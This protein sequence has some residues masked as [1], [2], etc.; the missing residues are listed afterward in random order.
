MT[1]TEPTLL[2][3][4]DIYLFN[5]GRGVR[6]YDVLGAHLTTVDGK[7]GVYFAVWAP[8]AASV[9]V[10]GDFNFWGAEANPLAPRQSSGIWEGFVPGLEQGSVY[11][12]HIESRANGYKVDKADP[13]GFRAE[14]PPRTASMVWDLDYA[15][16][17]G[18]WM[19]N[20]RAKQTLQSPVSIYELHMGS[21]RRIPEE[22]NRSMSYREIAAPLA[23]HVRN[24][25]FTH[26]EL[27]P[28]M[29]H[30][31]YGSWGYQSVGYFAPTS[32]YGTPQDFMYLVDYLHQQ[33]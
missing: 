9:S 6:L 24:L 3:N 16:Q 10:V 19:T 15:W 28:I 29:E 22:D 17:D 21:W 14:T 23:E 33:G 4:D 27:M 8:N 25:G 18:G 7:K 32:R 31:F 5:E 13:F 1:T 11:K 20:R 26:V 12:Y 30:P 2:T